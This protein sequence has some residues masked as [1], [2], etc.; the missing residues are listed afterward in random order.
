MAKTAQVRAALSET[1]AVIENMLA[2]GPLCAAVVEAAEA[3]AAALSAGKKILF[4]GNGGSA[5]DAQHWAG[6]LVARFYYDRPGLAAIA[7]TTDASVLTAIGNDYGYEHVFSRQVDALGVEGDVLFALST[8]GNSPNVVNALRAARERG[9]K[10][11]GFTGRDGGRMAGLCD[12]LI[13]IPSSC[14]PRVQEGHEL[15]GHTI[16]QMI[17]ADLFPRKDG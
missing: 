16:C 9:V 14:T 4:C 6:E 3:G 15:L 17:E 10:T 2:D 1:K 8:S 13:A 12:L 5:A 11:V 7:L